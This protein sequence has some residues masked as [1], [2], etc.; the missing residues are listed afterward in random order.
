[1][2][3]PDD[4]M[5]WWRENELRKICGEII[6]WLIANGYMNEH[7]RDKAINEYVLHIRNNQ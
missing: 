5:L 4:P 3:M 6:D 2:T 7:D 1:M